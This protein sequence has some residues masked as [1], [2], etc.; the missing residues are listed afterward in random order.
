V[1]G[2]ALSAASAKRWAK[3]FT[4]T[5]ATLLARH[6]KLVAGKWGYRARRKPGRPPTA[7]AIKQLVVRMATAPRPHAVSEE[8]WLS[9]RSVAFWTVIGGISG[10]AALLLALL[11]RSHIGPAGH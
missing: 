1:V 4:V 2:C 5:P 7:A 8:K 11:T 3:V 6:R 9:T 10:A